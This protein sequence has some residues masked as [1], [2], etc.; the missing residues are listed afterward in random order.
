MTQRRLCPGDVVEVRA[1][2]EILQTLDAEGTLNQ[3]PF[4]PEMLG[5]C[6]HRFRVARRAEM[7]CASGMRSPRGFMI[8]DVVTLEGV[9]CS[10]AAHDECQKACTIFWREAWLRKVENIITQSNKDLAGG[11]QLLARLKVTNVNNTYFCQASELAKFTY[12]L[13]RVQRVEKYL[14]GLHAGN[15]TVWQIARD[16]ALWLF[17]KIRQ[18]FLGIYM[19]GTNKSSPAQSLNLQ[20]GE[21]VEVKSRDSIL[22]T[23][24]ESRG[25]RGLVFFPGMHLFCGRRYR[26]RGRLDR[27]IADGTGEMRKL[28]NTVLLEG[29]TCKCSYLGFGVGGCSRCEFAYWREIWLRRANNPGTTALSATGGRIGKT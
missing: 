29:V 9:R 17:W 20:Q 22:T 18:L 4:M 25:N 16:I 11:A 28:K 19:R 26:V 2:E 21:L 10:G 6:G 3:L 15:F 14:N 1:P 7:T 13:S 27:L 12:S 24:N 23:L 5:F 8:D